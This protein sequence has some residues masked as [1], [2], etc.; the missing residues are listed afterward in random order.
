MSNLI[1]SVDCDWLVWNIL[2]NVA[3]WLIHYY[4]F[5]LARIFSLRHN[6]S[7]WDGS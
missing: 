3:D 1:N 2:E 4:R 6:A 7:V 5:I